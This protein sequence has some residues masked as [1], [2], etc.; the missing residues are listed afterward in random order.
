M[1]QPRVMIAGTHSGSGKTTVTCGLLQALKNRGLQVS[2][3]KCGPDYIDP[4]FHSKVIGTRSRNLD[5]FFTEPDVLRYLFCRAAL[6]TDISVFEGVM[7]FYDGITAG[8]I[9]GSSH[10]VSECTETPVILVVDAHGASISCV[11][12]IEGFSKFAPNR[13]SG[14]ILN[15]MSPALCEQLAP[16]IE[17]RTGLKVFGCLPRMKDIGISSRHL[18]L[19]MPDEIQS[20]EEKLSALATEMEKTVDIDGILELA[21]TAGDVSGEPPSVKKLDTKVRIAFADDEA[22]CFTYE[23]NKVLLEETGAELV[24]FSPVHDTSLPEDVSGIVLSGGYPELYVRELSSNR[25]ML[26]SIRAA[27][28][29]GMPCMAECGGF[30]YLHEKI[31]TEDGEYPFVGA[32]RGTVENTGRLSRFGYVT[33]SSEDRDSVIGTCAKGHEFHYWDSD[34]C[35]TAWKAVKASGKEY[36]CGHEGNGM[37]A[38]FP[39][40]YYY[41]DPG[42]PYR[43]LRRCQEYRPRGI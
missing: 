27:I 11:P 17:V 36:L 14:V 21:G 42:I 20:I 34:N 24:N 6:G 41:S 16:V 8:G 10:S 35:G 12:V 19:M 43:F 13:I 29:G 1:K 40:L 30:M 33:L 28:E 26:D 23:D 32:V 39:H 7:G 2:S 5:T 4:M 37:V 9:E 15:N 18:G 25:P 3:F 22:F 31:R 38:G